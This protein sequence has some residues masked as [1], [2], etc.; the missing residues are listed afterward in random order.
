MGDPGYVSPL[1]R[2]V[3]ERLPDAPRILERLAAQADREISPYEVVPTGTVMRWV[4]G[5]ALRGRFSVVKSLVATG[6]RNA[7]RERVRAERLALLA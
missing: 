3:Y 2:L 5:A 7:A 4:L 6:K 1:N